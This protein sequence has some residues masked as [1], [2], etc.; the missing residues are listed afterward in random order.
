MQTFSL[1]TPNVG[2]SEGQKSK[3][4]NILWW[5]APLNSLVYL[6][7]LSAAGAK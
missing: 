5:Q 7:A 1:A 6:V 4:E 3:P 2:P